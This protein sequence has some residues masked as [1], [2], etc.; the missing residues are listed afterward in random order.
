MKLPPRWQNPGIAL[1]LFLL[2]IVTRVPFRSRMLYHWDSVNFALGLEHYDVY[3]HQPHPP[4][5]FLYVMVGRLFSFLAGDANAGLVWLSII[6]TGLAAAAIFGVGQA[7]W[8]RQTGILASLLLLTSPLFWF[9]GEV[10][11]SYTVEAVFVLTVALLCYRHLTGADDRLWLSAIVLG[12]AG[13]FR[14]NTMLFLLPLWAAAAWRFRWRRLVGATAALALT[15]LAW[16][17]PMLAL[18]GGPTR[19]LDALGAASQGVAAE[20]SLADVRQMAVNGFRLTM[21][22]AYALGIGLIFL[23]LGI[24]YGLWR[25]RRTAR[26]RI[27]LPQIH[28]F[29]WWLAPSLLFYTFMHI[30]QPGHTFTFMPALLLILSFILTRGLPATLRRISRQGVWVSAG[31]ILLAN[32]TF[33]LTAPPYLF[34]ARRIVFTSPSWPTIRQRDTSLETRIAYIRANLPPD[35]TAILSSGLDFRH[36]DFYLREYPIFRYATLP[37]TA[38]VPLSPSI[39]T[40]VL[41][42]EGLQGENCQTV[43]LGSVERLCRIPRAPDQD[44]VIEGTTVHLRPSAAGQTL[45]FACSPGRRE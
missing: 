29:F 45:H 16:V 8:D 9:H 44:V 28:L 33:F 32:I 34:G 35:Q 21:F 30:R 11:L 3:L 41:F 14:Q 6:A 20:S 26:A 5:Y 36:P 39:R 10:A 31:L 1:G 42:G 17:L 15:C 24:G 12:I 40:L 37:L 13:G 4:G 19:Y 38:S 7:L 25:Y 43:A 23:L 22:T 2:G 27:R 18:S